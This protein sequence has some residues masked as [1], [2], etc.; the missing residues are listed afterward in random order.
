MTF[1]RYSLLLG[2]GLQF[3][4]PIM[5]AAG[6]TDVMDKHLNVIR[7]FHQG[8]LQHAESMAI[9]SS[10]VEQYRERL[11]RAESLSGPR[12]NL[13]ANYTRLDDRDPGVDPDQ[14]HTRV[15]LT[16]PIFHGYK[17]QSGVE[18][19]TAELQ[20]Q[21][22]LQNQ[23]Q[24]LL[25]TR[26]A[27]TYF[28]IVA[29]QRDIGNLQAQQKVN[30]KRTREI[31]DRVRIGRSRQAD[32][33]TLEAQNLLV[34]NQ[35]QA[36][37]SQLDAGWEELTYLTGQS[38]RDLPDFSP[39]K[40]PSLPAREPLMRALAQRPDLLALQK[41][42]EVSRSQITVSRSGRYPSLDLAGNYYV[43][44]EG[45]QEPVKWDIGLT[46]NYPL[47]EGG[48]IRAEVAEASAKSREQELRYTQAHRL[49]TTQI[50]SALQNL[51]H[52]A[53]QAAI[54][55]KA[56]QTLERNYQEQNRDYNLSLVTSLE[57]LQAQNTLEE[58]RRSRDRLAIQILQNIVAVKATAGIYP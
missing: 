45:P 6:N 5:A 48:Q 24:I 34:A 54:L 1:I 7:E 10:R 42:A 49:A 40:S 17:E 19:A 11:N 29:A 16:H 26:V 4:G 43:L 30:G 18:V 31:A 12:L 8:A 57:V 36:A 3:S 52:L 14:Y 38:R 28:S 22:A 32:L 58:T 44:R 39:A 21:E 37:R 50:E 2:L 56:M 46:L 41:Q 51:E 20:V 23:E 55:D 9:Q 53:Q 13:I 47:Y 33:L 27:Q 35:L 15:N 25:F